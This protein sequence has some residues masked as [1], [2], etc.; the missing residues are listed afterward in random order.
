MPEPTEEQVMAELIRDEPDYAK[1]I[2]AITLHGIQQYVATGRPGGYFLRCLL[3]NDLFGVAAYA[4]A[5]NWAALSDTIKY[6]NNRIPA[7]CYGTSLH[8][9]SWI[10]K[11]RKARG[12]LPIMAEGGHTSDSTAEGM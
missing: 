3:S 5:E 12:E 10:D 4:D 2:P 9:V 8:Y 11:K 7:E 6:I 1:D